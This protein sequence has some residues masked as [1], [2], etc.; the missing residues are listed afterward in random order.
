MFSLIEYRKIIKRT[1]HWWSDE[2]RLHL[3]RQHLPSRLPVLVSANGTPNTPFTDVVYMD[4]T[5]EVWYRV[6]GWTPLRASVIRALMSEFN[7]GQFVHSVVEPRRDFDIIRTV[8][9]WY[10][11]TPIVRCSYEKLTADRADLN[12]PFPTDKKWLAWSTASCKP[13]S[14]EDVYINAGALAHA[15]ETGKLI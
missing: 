12:F 8:V 9:Y 13:Y 2:S 1:L 6:P 15:R 5:V 11:V 14:T 10:D 7:M 4:R 3:V